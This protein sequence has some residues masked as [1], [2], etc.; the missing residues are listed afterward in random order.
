[1][2][3]V[4]AQQLHDL[5]DEGRTD[6]AKVGLERLLEMG[7]TNIE[8]LKLKAFF[9][10]VEGRFDLELEVWKKVLKVDHED[11]DA[12]D[13][14]LH[15]Q[16]EDKELFY[17]TD[18]T[19]TGRRYLA[20]PKA[21]VRSSLIGLAG[22]LGFLTLSKLQLL[23]KSIESPN[24]SIAAF[25][26]L[27]ITPWVFIIYNWVKSLKFI[28]IE[29]EGITIETRFKRHY[30]KWP[31]LNSLSMVHSH[32]PGNEVLFLRIQSKTAEKPVIHLDLEHN[33]SSL[34]ARTHFVEEL[35]EAYPRLDYKNI[36]QLSA[37]DQKILQI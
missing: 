27:V 35:K 7:P 17:F 21:L 6:E 36:D 10:E 13:F 37:G 11:E 2:D 25:F 3:I 31:E 33:S 4:N 28:C 22:C 29:D 16:I 23:G 12:V 20:Y 1:M 14:F 34:K 19:K 15:K 5:Y 24:G 9:Y 8:A 26:A 32:S 18:E 30:F